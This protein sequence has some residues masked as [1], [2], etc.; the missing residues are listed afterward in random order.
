[1]PH[2]YRLTMFRCLFGPLRGERPNASRCSRDASLPSF[3]V[4]RLSHSPLTARNWPVVMNTAR[5]LSPPSQRVFGMCCSYH[6]V[7][8]F[9]ANIAHELKHINRLLK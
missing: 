5:Q 4:K 6:Y 7:Q 3:T 1:M 9:G 8:E 2:G